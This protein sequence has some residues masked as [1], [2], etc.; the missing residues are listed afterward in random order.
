MIPNLDNVL[1]IFINKLIP[2]TAKEVKLGNKIFGAF[3]ID[4]K[5]HNLIVI[6][7]NNEKDNPL[8]HGEITTIINFFKNSNLNPKDYF[9]ITSHEPCSLCLSAI[10][11]AGFDNFCYFFPY[12]DTELTFN[13]PHDLKILNEV[14]GIKNGQYNTSNSY[15]KSYSILNEI[16]SLDENIYKRDLL[17]KSQKI[18]D[19]YDK[20]SIIYQKNKENNNIPLN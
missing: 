12:Q 20:L 13:I 4:K 16:D 5:K 1:N 11:W 15:W 9:F 3:I 7:T 14:F 6:G 8:Y 18:K 2:E 17:T 19:S 10:T